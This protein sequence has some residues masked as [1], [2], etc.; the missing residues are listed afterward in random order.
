MWSSGRSSSTP[1]IF[2]L[3]NPIAYVATG[4]FRDITVTC[5]QY[6]LITNISLYSYVASQQHFIFFS[7]TKNLSFG[8]GS[9]PDLGNDDL[10]THI[11]L[12]VCMC[13]GVYI[14][15]PLYYADYYFFLTNMNLFICIL[16]RLFEADI[17][18][19]TFCDIGKCHPQVSYLRINVVRFFKGLCI[20]EG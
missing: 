4:I 5:Q 10:R 9:D 7:V 1:Y 8:L 20:S 15:E 6:Y 2:S 13:V 17:V 16:Q 18:F 3:I 14:I 11:G 19:C 12:C